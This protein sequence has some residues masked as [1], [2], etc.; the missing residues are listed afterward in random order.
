MSDTVLPQGKTYDEVC[1]RFRWSIPASFN[2][3]VDICDRHAVADASR[4]AMIFEDE[5]GAAHEH[6]FAEFRARSNQLARALARLGVKRGE[7]VGIVLSQRPETAVAHLAAYKLGAIALPLATLF[8]PEALQ[9]RLGNAGV[10]VVITDPG[11][12]ERLLGVQKNLPGLAHIVSVDPADAD[13]VLDYRKLLE[14]E[15]DSF[16]PVK[17][18]SEDG[19]LLIYTSGTTGPPKGALHAH[20]IGL[21]RL[22]SME[23]VHQYFPKPGDRFWTPADWAWAGGL[24]DMLLPSWHYGVTVVAHRARKF[25]PAHAFALM[26]RHKVRNVFL[27]GTVL[28][29]MRKQEEALKSEDVRLRTIHTGGETVGEEVIRWTE[30]MLGTAPHEGFGQT[31]ILMMLANCAALMPI[32]PG[33]MGRPVPGHEVDL[34]D[35]EG[36]PVPVGET[37]EICINRGV[38]GMFLRYWNDEAATREKFHGDWL[39]TADLGRKDEDGYFWYVGRKDDVIS[40]GAYRI[41][42]GEIEACLLGHPSVALAAA[43][44]SPD[45]IRGEVVKAFVQLREGVPQTPALAQALQ[46]YVRNRLSAHEYPRELEFIDALPTTTTGKLMRGEL[47]RL[48]RQRKLGK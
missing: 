12:L 4:V 28:K 25:D 22:P 47:R 11:S 29:M 27:P 37:G 32:K 10:R 33:S 23:F 38:P 26:A 40:S 17:T 18:S 2:I 20:R 45:P 35:D 30:Q 39:R 24:L 31:E 13:Q 41:G 19:A 36:R 3:A 15:P 34:L 16:D 42:P 6:T 44:G 5:S 1:A 7:C 14:H 9:H 48:E 8:G 46:E 21:G 43:I